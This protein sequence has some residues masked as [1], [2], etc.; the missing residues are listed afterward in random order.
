MTLS[1][2]GDLMGFA[3]AGAILAAYGY[4]TFGKHDADARYHA[5]NLLGAALLGVSLTINYNLAS[6]CLEGAW[7]MIALYGLIE[8]W[9]TGR[10]LDQ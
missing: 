7:G 10:L 2:F 1:Q 9:R 8:R 6:L 4:T 3:G 5:L